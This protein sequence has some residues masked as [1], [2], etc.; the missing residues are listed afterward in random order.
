MNIRKSKL[1][2]IV[3]LGLL[4]SYVVPGFCRAQEFSRKGKFELSGIF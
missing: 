3:I 2:T 1:S 4:V